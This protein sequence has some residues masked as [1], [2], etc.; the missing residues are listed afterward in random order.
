MILPPSRGHDVAAAGPRCRR[1]HGPALAANSARYG[2]CGI[3]STNINFQI[4]RMRI[5]VKTLTTAVACLL[6]IAGIAQQKILSGVVTDKTT[7][8][9]LSG[10]TVT[11]NRKSVITDTSGRYSIPAVAGSTVYFS[12]VGLQ[13]QTVKWDGSTMPQV[14]LDRDPNSNLNEVV[15][16][17]YQTQRKIDLT[18]AVAVVS[19][20]DIKDI[21]NSN[22]IQA[23]QGHVPGLYV[24]S[25]GDPGAQNNTIAIRGFNTLGYFAPLY[26]IDGVPTIT[27][28]VFQALDPNSIQ[29]IQVLKDASSAS[30]YGSRASNGVIIVT[31]KQG[32]KGKVHLQFNNSITS[33]DYATRFKVLDAQGQGRAIWQA[34]IN[35]G[36]DPNSVTSLFSYTQHTGT[37]GYPVLDKVNIFPYLNG[38]SSE[39]AANTN[40]QDVVFKHGIITSND[41]TITAGSENSNLLINLN[42]LDN[43]GIMRYNGYRRYGA[44]INGST[45]LFDHKLRI[46]NNLQFFTA[47]ETPVP[48]DLGGASVLYDALFVSPLIPVYTTTGGYGGPIGAGFSDRDNPLLTLYINRWN[49][50]NEYN[51]FGNLYAELTPIK[52]LTLRSNFGY[53]YDNVSDRQILQTYSSGFIS[54]TVN[55]LTLTNN[56][57]LDLTW[58]NTANYHLQFGQSRLDL[59][60]GIEAVKRTYVTSGD[61]KQGFALQTNNYFQLS[62]GTGIT[63]NSGT[64]TG[65]QLL[66]YFGKVN[67]TFADKYLVS[68]TLRADGSSRFGTNNQYGLFPAASVGW[69]INNENFMKN[70]TWISDLKL[71]S[72]FGITGNQEAIADENKLALYATNYGT[73]GQTGSNQNTGQFAN[74]GTAYDI[75]GAGTGNLPS[76]YVAVQAANPNLKWES[77]REF[78][79]GVDFGLLSNHI[80]GSVD[81]F[82]RKTTNIIVQPPYAGI[83]GE[84]Q[85]AYVNGATKTNKGYEVSLGYQNHIGKLTYQVNA[86]VFGFRDKITYLPSTVI[87]AYAGNVQNT[88]LGHSQFAQFGYVVQGIFQ[89]QQEVTSHATQTGAAVGRL[90]YKDLNGNGQID[91]LD[92]TWLGNAVPDFNYGL[93]VN[94][95]YEAFSF[96]FFLQG[97]HGG[98]VA[99][100]HKANTDF[101]GLNPGVNFGQ[102]TLDAWTPQNTGSNIPALSLV[103]NNQEGRFSSYYIE[104][105]SYM[106]IRNVQLGYTL[107]R[108]DLA[109]LK[110]FDAIKFYVMGENLVTFYKKHGANAFTGQ[111]PENP[112][113]NYPIP[114]K[115]TAGVNISF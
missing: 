41:I 68:A 36:A 111:D 85:N 8:Q 6:C 48:S 107:P 95:A 70:V 93:Q 106:K 79:E 49:K 86:N 89:N 91:A 4:K 74:N 37:G 35:D 58:S 9:P 65:N 55:S 92:Q 98:V 28:S 62:S 90:M 108:K 76:G 47:S 2:R 19:L 14:E 23:L 99:N 56:H 69:R 61:Y 29:T 60:G 18:G 104:S 12:Y 27:P 57:E 31:T 40:W 84:G 77:T 44:R 64:S 43:N 1:R 94:L 3:G 102:R 10:V 88:I 100:Q 72:S 115:L 71:R 32:A 13:T 26:V 110:V 101:V 105:G 53:S 17:G 22:P 15:V 67:Y 96:S 50:N 7:H 81:Y 39:P 54:R 5:L 59:L 63:T 34:A 87:S 80:F 51:L 25:D 109:N 66:S 114:R 75:N 20:N 46:G 73:I 82:S 78:N 97:V 42:Y 52:G 30:I 11:V 45:D 103:D 21:P 16:T 24:T 38:D 113:N 112:G 33:E 83:L